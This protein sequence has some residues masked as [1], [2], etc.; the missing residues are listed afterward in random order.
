MVFKILIKGDKNAG[1]TELGNRL[2][3]NPFS[4]IYKT[5]SSAAFYQYEEPDDK[6]NIDTFKLW[7][8]TNDK[9]YQA[10][11][12]IQ[13]RNINVL[14]YCINAS[15]S[16]LADKLPD[17]KTEIDEILASNSDARLIVVAT[18]ID[19]KEIEDNLKLIQK[20]AKE[21][22]CPC[23]ETSAKDNTGIDQLKQQI[24]VSARLAATTE[25]LNPKSISAPPA[26]TTEPPI[27]PESV[28][29]HPAATT[30]SPINPER[31]RLK[32]IITTLIHNIENGTGRI[33]SGRDSAKVT[34]LKDVLTAITTAENFD[35]QAT[36]GRLKK[37]CAEQ[38]HPWRLF[39]TPHS[40][41]E[42]EKLLVPS[43]TISTLS[44]K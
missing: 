6:G 31:E 19:L 12:I 37:I 42:L 40:A 26:A 43:P 30:E 4:G 8:T 18:K 1:K 24:S 11:T 41:R 32:E 9:K 35:E 13:Q 28:P 25:P 16:N 38:R 2:S 34:K 29:A 20:F 7:E 23:I 5:T 44:Q 3:L 27:N 15:Q 21:N 36:I 22:A 17:Y 14:I 10:L 39:H 33:T